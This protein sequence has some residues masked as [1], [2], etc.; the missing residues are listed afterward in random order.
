M[1]LAGHESNPGQEAQRAMAL[2][3][4]ITCE[5]RMNAGFRRQ[6]RRRRADRMHAGF[7]IVRND[8]PRVVWLLR[9]GLF[10]NLDLTVDA[11]RAP[12]SFVVHSLK[13]ARMLM[14][15]K[16]AMK[17]PPSRIIGVES[18]NHGCFRRHQ[19]R[20]AQ[21]AGKAI[22]VDGDDLERMAMQVHGMR[23][24]RLI[25]SFLGSKPS[26]SDEEKRPF[27]GVSL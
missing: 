14:V 8:S 24:H 27:Y 16:V 23:H 21:G 26:S 6:V 15:Q 9:V 5:S 25:V 20:V 11:G 12:S 1:D 4:V 3:L 10:Q 7:F 18:H 13:H 19:H 22:A 17:S 2:I